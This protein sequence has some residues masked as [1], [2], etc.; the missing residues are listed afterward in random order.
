MTR[1]Q[2]ITDNY[3]IFQNAYDKVRKDE[4]QDGHEKEMQAMADGL[5]EIE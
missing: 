2:C 4:K 3:V 1:I 5:C